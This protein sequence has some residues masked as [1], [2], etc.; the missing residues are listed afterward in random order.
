[1]HNQDHTLFESKVWFWDEKQYKQAYTQ[2]TRDYYRYSENDTPVLNEEN[3]VAYLSSIRK[4]IVRPGNTLSS[5]A[6][7]YYGAANQWPL[8][9]MENKNILSNPNMLS[10]N[11]ELVIPFIE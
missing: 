2:T 3:K 4:H 10:T 11:T 8:I 9:F 5:I 1:M 6:K 7:T